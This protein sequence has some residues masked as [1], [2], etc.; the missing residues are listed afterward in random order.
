MI[1]TTNP[2]AQTGEAH[3]ERGVH[4]PAIGVVVLIDC[5]GGRGSVLFCSGFKPSSSWC[6]GSDRDV[7]GWRGVVPRALSIRAPVARVL[8]VCERSG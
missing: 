4:H 7:D 8:T 2:S 1:T 6:A 5:V 3:I